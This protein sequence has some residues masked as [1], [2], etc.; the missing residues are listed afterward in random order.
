LDKY[1]NVSRKD[2]NNKMR[3]I[4]IEKESVFNLDRFE[5]L[6]ANAVK[7]IQK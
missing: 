2:D 3:T 7:L 6:V 4:K 5:K 1:Q